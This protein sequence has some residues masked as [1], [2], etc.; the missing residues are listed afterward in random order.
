[1]PGAPADRRSRSKSRKRWR[2]ARRIVNFLGVGIIRHYGRAN[3][4]LTEFG[5]LPFR[6][7]SRQVKKAPVGVPAAAPEPGS[8]S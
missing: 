7:R 6:S 3:E 4:K 2:R 5:L 1:V 8:T